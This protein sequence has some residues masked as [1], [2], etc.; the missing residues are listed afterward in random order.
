[1]DEVLVATKL[2]A[3]KNNESEVLN[4]KV[5]LEKDHISMYV[6]SFPHFAMMRG[7]MEVE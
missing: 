7:V 1:M 5:P 3:Q 2:L 4:F 6:P